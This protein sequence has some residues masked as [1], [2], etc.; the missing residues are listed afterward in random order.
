MKIVSGCITNNV[1]NMVLIGIVGKKYS[2]KSTIASHLVDKYGFQEFAF[3]DPLKQACR[4]V[5]GLT[6]QQLYGS[7]VDKESKDPYWG[8]SPRHMLQDVG[9]MF[10]DLVRVRPEY[11]SIWIRSVERSIQQ[12][13]ARRVVVSDVRYEDEATMIRDKGG[14]LIG[15]YRSDVVSHDEH[16]S[17]NQDIRVDIVIRNN[18]SISDLH[19]KVDAWIGR[20]LKH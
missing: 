14:Y 13:R 8:V 1:N 9:K 18:G 19:D 7:V 12:A 15:V 6:H 17:E 10:R 3:A 2:G 20:L 4:D 5:F 16:E 11:H